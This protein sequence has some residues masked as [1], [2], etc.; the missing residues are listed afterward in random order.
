MDASMLISVA[1]FIAHAKLGYFVE[2]INYPNKTWTT[3][4]PVTFQKKVFV[5]RCF[6]LFYL[7]LL[8]QIDD[9]S[10]TLLVKK[11]PFGKL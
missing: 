9:F 11:Y 10:N 7:C 4:I 1:E 3:Q 5:E 8:L 6:F 2:I